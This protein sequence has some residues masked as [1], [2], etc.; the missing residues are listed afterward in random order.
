MKTVRASNLTRGTIVAETVE[1]A[2]D[3]WSRFWGLMGRRDLAAGRGILITPCS[4]IHMFFMRFPI[5][6]VYLDP[7]R[8]VKRIVGSLKPWR[9]SW[10][11]GAD[12]VLEAPAGWAGEA[13]LG[14]GAQVVFEDGARTD[15]A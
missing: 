2:S 6:V 5:D 8:R 3:P 12:A 4:S 13:G 10:C 7:S 14:E 15:E 9:I 11:R 1:V